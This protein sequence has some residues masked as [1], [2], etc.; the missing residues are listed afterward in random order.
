MEG[1]TYNRRI[2][3]HLSELEQN[4]KYLNQLQLFFDLQKE[5]LYYQRPINAQIETD[6]QCTENSLSHRNNSHEA[7]LLAWYHW[8]IPNTS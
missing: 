3:M 4:S 8:W 5:M 6:Q 7:L 1:K 2:S